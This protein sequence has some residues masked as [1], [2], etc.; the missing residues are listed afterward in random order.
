MGIERGHKENLLKNKYLPRR[1][2]M[3]KT[4]RKGTG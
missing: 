2:A 4:R 3:G 1:A